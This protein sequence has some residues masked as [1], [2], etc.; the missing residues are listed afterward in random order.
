MDLKDFVAQTLVQIV[1]GV[2]EA[3]QHIGE[4]ALVS[5]VIQ[6]GQEHASNQ[7]FISTAN[8]YAQTVKFD[9][10]VK[11]SE[12]KVGKASGGIEVLSV[13]IGA[14]GSKTDTSSSI[15][16]VQFAVPVVLPGGV[17]D[18]SPLPPP[19]LFPNRSKKS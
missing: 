7:G 15:S 6:S 9:V 11:A 1:E 8:G 4:H 19:T 18:G 2:T 17:R 14:S 10:A 5:P 13:S 12:G 3:Q 16:R